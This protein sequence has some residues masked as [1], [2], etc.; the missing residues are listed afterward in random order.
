MKFHV[1]SLFPDMMN[2][3]SSWGVV[4]RAL[5]SQKVELNCVNPRDFTEDVHK[6]VDDRPFGGGDGMVLMAEPLKRALGSL[7]SPGRVVALTATGRTWNHSRAKEW[8]KEQKDVTLICGRYAGFDQRFI[9]KYVDEEISIGDFILSGGELAACVII[10]SVCRFVPGVLGHPDSPLAESFELGGL[11]APQY[12][13][14]QEWEGLPVPQALTGGNHREIAQFRAAVS[15]LWTLKRRPDLL[16]G[17]SSE[18]L[19]SAL[20]MVESLPLSERKSLGL[21]DLSFVKRK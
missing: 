20:K 18:A 13:R 14:P 8:A 21:L 12:T 11:E 17:D 2:S 15:L 9:E 16:Q 6:T 10:D 5:S 7:S 4:G 1:I 3:L 19:I